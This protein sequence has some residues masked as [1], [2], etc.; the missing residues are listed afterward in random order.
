[1]S[2]ANKALARRIVEEAF[3]AGRLEVVDELVARDY[4]GHDPSLPEDARG[5]EG[6]K[7]LIAGYRVAFPDIRVTVED[8]IAE[9]DMVVTRWAPP[10]P[11]RV[12]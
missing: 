12:S 3:T 2:A 1:M 6:V 11:T 9:G 10:A 5:P 7:E 4:V 8:Q